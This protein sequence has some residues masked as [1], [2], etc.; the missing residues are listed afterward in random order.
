MLLGSVPIRGVY[1]TAFEVSKA[2]LRAVELP[3]EWGVPDSLHT[4]GADFLAGAFA[5]CLS[6]AVVIPVDVV[7]QRLMVQNASEGAVM[8]RNGWAAARGILATEGLSGLYRG[9]GA[10]LLLFVPSSGLWW[11]AYG[12]YQTGIWSVLHAAEA[13]VDVVPVQVTAALMA[14]ATSG[15]L[16][17]P[18]DVVKTRLQTCSVLQGQ[19]PPT[20]RSIATALLRE[21][22]GVQTRCRGFTDSHP[23]CRRGCVA[24]SGGWA[25]VSPAPCCGGPPCPA[26]SRC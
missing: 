24:S 2:R 22:R 15:L 19:A 21:V 10:S 4:G 7:S 1:L 23:G 26:P 17:T 18:L 6:Q 13:R 14:G 9:A 8:Y 5:S 25:R 3:R 16:T 11:G 20:F 12:A